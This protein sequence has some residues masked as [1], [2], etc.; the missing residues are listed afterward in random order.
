LLLAAI[1]VWCVGGLLLRLAAS[2]CFLCAAG[3]LALGDAV[4]SLGAAGCGLACWIGAQLLYRVRRGR[5]HWAR[6][7]R[8]FGRESAGPSHYGGARPPA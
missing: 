2:S 7:A 4:S 1:V 6:A 5:W 3:L 8:L